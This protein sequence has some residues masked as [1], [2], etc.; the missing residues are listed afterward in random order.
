M[1]VQDTLEYANMINVRAAAVHC[2]ANMPASV[3]ANRHVHHHL[4]WIDDG[5]PEPDHDSGSVRA[6]WLLRIL[7]SHGYAVSFQPRL[8]RPVQYTQLL[9]FYGIHVLP[10]RTPSQLVLQFDDGS[11]WYHGFIIS[12]PDNYKEYSPVIKA[13]CPRAPVIYDTVDVHFLREARAM[14][15]EGTFAAVKTIHPDNSTSAYGSA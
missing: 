8:D 5:V 13:A 15:L 3:A 10:A 2:P 7:V 1:Y 6:A 12:R 14:L 9:R 4:L 11:C